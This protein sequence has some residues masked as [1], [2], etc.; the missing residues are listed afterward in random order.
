MPLIC[1]ILI[2]WDIKMSSNNPLR[3]ILIGQI[4]C[5]SMCNFIIQFQSNYALHM[6]VKWNSFKR[7]DSY[8]KTLILQL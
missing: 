6:T 5:L 2:K 7:L 8:N 4:L 3:E 1:Y